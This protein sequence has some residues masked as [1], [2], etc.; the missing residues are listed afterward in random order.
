MKR[1]R[2]EVID[3]LTR[4]EE[5]SLRWKA[6]VRVLDEPPDS[7]KVKDLQEEIRTSPR[8]QALI[9]GRDQRRERKLAAEEE[10]RTLLQSEVDRWRRAKANGLLQPRHR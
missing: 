7:R 10:R 3:A 2:T 8:A 1:T 5:P 6:M 9:A 4:S